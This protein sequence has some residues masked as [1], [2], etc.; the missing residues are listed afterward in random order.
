MFGEAIL[1]ALKAFCESCTKCLNAKKPSKAKKVEACPQC[2]KCGLDCSHF[3]LHVFKN[4]GLDTSYLTTA[5]MRTF[6]GRNFSDLYNLIDLGSSETRVMSGDLAVYPGHVVLVTKVYPETLKAD[7]I[8]V[9]SGKDIKNA[10]EA[11]QSEKGISLKTLEVL[12]KGF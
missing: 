7:I 11:V 6:L 8:H 3:I 9:T 12:C 10:G 2:Q 5:A 1:S 4:S